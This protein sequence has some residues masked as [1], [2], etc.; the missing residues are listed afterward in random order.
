MDLMS[1]SILITTKK[2]CASGKDE[3]EDW[4]TAANTAF[5]GCPLANFCLLYLRG[6]KM[7]GF[8]LAGIFRDTKNL[9][10]I[11]IT[12]I[13]LWFIL[14][15]KKKLTWLLILSIWTN[16]LNKI[17][18]Q[19]QPKMSTSTIILKLINMAQMC[20]PSPP[21]KFP[22]R[23]MQPFFGC[24]GTTA[25]SIGLM[26]L[27]SSPQGARARPTERTGWP[28]TH[29]AVTSHILSTCGEKKNWPAGS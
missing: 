28:Q 11:F 7:L 27:T 17:N 13:L 19:T 2:T 14:S 1:T 29:V 18:S 15:I 12:I 9:V 22:S 24:L 6:A 5:E 16:I 25:R 3:L 4:C 20:A 26:R 23:S 21:M 8:R 10:L